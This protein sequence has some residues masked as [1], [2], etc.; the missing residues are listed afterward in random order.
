M[1]KQRKVSN[2][3][4]FNLTQK[5]DARRLRALAQMVEEDYQNRVRAERL[6]QILE[7]ERRK[8]LSGR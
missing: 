2:R 4:R 6:R 3:Q 7:W 1:R 5:R 8:F